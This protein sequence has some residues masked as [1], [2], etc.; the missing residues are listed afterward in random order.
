MYEGRGPRLADPASAS[1][2]VMAES[3]SG[4]IERVTFHNLDNGYCVLRVTA[5]GHR[6]PVTVVGTLSQAIVG[7][8]LD[9]QGHWVQDRNHGAQFK[10][11]DLRTHPPHTLTGII[12]YLGSG[13]VKG[14]G[15]TYAKKIV[16]VF[17][18]KTLEIIDRSPSFLSQVKGIGPK[19]IQC[20]RD[21]WKE[22]TAVRAIMTFLLSYG[23]GTARA[24]RIYKTYGEN[25]IELV[26][27]NPYRLAEDIWGIGF[28]TADKLAQQ[29]GLP[30]DSPL[31]ARAALR[32]VLN[33]ESRSRGH[34]ALPELTLLGAAQEL[35]E[36]PVTILEAA[37]TE[38]LQ[39]NEFIREETVNGALLYL[40]A[41]HAAEKGVAERL[42]ALA[43]GPHP[44]TIADPAAALAWVE[45]Q[46]T[47]TLAPSQQAA[48]LQAIQQKLLVV[49]GGPGTGKTTIIKAILAIFAAKKQRI[50]LA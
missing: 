47:I 37:L 17:G 34:V 1:G 28:D 31:R 36:I 16:D 10:A 3:L 43:T 27:Q 19:R 18:E 20:I 41:L 29:I 42:A 44:L 13:L 40:A 48:I 49:T 4:V 26:R 45:T 11:D 7:E 14:I 39:A 12:K 15:P 22:A 21:G 25:A 35:T 33:E 2:I 6:E 5:R 30:A 8:F 46:M 38:L 23:M 50:A 24:V 32:Y 9:A